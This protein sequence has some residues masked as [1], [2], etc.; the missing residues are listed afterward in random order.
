MP[1]PTAGSAGDTSTAPASPAATPADAAG[2]AADAAGT[3]AD[4]AGA[5]GRAAIVVLGGL[6]ALGPLTTDLY[7]P[8]LPAIADD[9]VAEPA[10]VQLTL[11]FSM[12]GVAAGQLIFGPLSDR[13]GRRPPLLAGLVVYTLA[14]IVC[15][16]APDL[17][18]LIAARFVQGAAGAAGL[19]IGRAVAR[20]RFEG[21]AM[22]RFLASI[23]LISGLAPILAPLFGAQMLRFTSWRGTFGALAALGLLLT[24]VAFAALRETLPPSARR[25]GGL[26][27]TLRTMGGLLRDMPFLGLLLTSTF[28]FGALF[29]YISG[30]SVVLQ[31]VYHVSPQ[32]YSLLFGLNSVAIVGAT[33]LNGR[34]LA[35]RFTAGALM[36]TGLAVM[37]AAGVSLVLV[38]AVWDLGLVAVC[39]SLFVMMASLG[40]VLPNSAARALSLVAPQSAGSASALLGTGTFLCGA[41]VAPLSSLGG[42]PSAV[43]LAVVVLSCSVLSAASYLLLLRPARTAPADATEPAAA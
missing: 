41:V 23:T 30:S 3:P 36:R 24:L 14:S 22:I 8:G 7:L 34:V 31:H 39:A 1:G 28:A 42:S 5:T 19:V 6:V 29:G 26:S 17:T 32:T 16:I 4:A 33:Q 18:T 43:L 40:M 37:I 25:G 38:T 12:F 20:D 11:T 9:L 10:A 15:V 27:G 21:V 13:F 35:P 2:T